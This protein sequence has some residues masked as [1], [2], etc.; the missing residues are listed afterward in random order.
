MSVEQNKATVTAFSP[1]VQG[2]LPRGSHRL[3]RCGERPKV[4]SHASGSTDGDVLWLALGGGGGGGGGGV[5]GASRYV[6][7]V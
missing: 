7:T 2:K 4:T 6:M 3:S 1:D 5:A